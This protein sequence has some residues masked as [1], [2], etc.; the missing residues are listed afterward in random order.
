[1]STFTE[2]ELAALHSIFAETPDL[3]PALQQQLAVATVTE[4]ENS[5][6][7]FFTTI[8]VDADAP[9]VVVSDVLGF[10]TQARVKGLEHGIGF[11]LFTKEG[12]ICLLEGFAWGPESTAAL[13]L[14]SLEFEIY[15][16]APVRVS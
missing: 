9:R 11:V 1:M 15:K 8:A 2:L 16:Q 13:D 14:Q 10:E 7:G 6:G 5:G 4:R 12:L 3:A